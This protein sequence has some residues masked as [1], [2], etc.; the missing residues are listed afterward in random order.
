MDIAPVSC[1]NYPDYLR[2]LFPRCRDQIDEELGPDAEGDWLVAQALT[3]NI[4]TSAALDQAVESGDQELTA[5]WYSA[6]EELLASPDADLRDAVLH[7]AA[8]AALGSAAR[9][10]LSQSQAGPLLASAIDNHY[11]D[12]TWRTK[13]SWVDEPAGYAV[14]ASVWIYWYRDELLMHGRRYSA[15]LDGYPATVPFARVAAVGR[16]DEIG[17]A[18]A[19]VLAEVGELSSDGQDQMAEFLAYAGG[20]E[21]RSLYTGSRIA[22]VEIVSFDGDVEVWAH[23]GV[24]RADLF[25]SDPTGSP[26]VSNWHR[27]DE[28]GAAV[29]AALHR[30]STTGW[31]GP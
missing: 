27:V 19:A 21:W 15:E 4:L 23:Q 12:A 2:R 7:G 22:V 31:V 5:R 6:I 24:Q 25:V 8:R 17:A 13:T 9:A 11:G 16:P 28:L 30:S 18:V 26:I 3:R 10:V 1:E 20:V 29:L 14:V